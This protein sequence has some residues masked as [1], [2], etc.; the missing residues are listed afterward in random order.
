M[1]SSTTSWL[2]YSIA[3]LRSFIKTRQEKADFPQV[4]RSPL[5]AP[6]FYCSGN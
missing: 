6:R 5:L 3:R 2:L 1:S 4:N